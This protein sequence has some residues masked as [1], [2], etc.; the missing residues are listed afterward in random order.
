MILPVILAG[1]TGSRL[2][3]MSRKNQP[4][5]LIGLHGELTML[6]ATISRLSGLICSAPIVICQE[7]H[8]FMVAEQLREMKV[9][10]VHIILEPVGKNTAPATALAA[11]IALQTEKNP[12]LLILSADFLFRELQIDLVVMMP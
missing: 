4:K 12:T 8:R 6:Q 5:Q 3:P 1:G 10:K 9:E 7:E 11:F 2:W